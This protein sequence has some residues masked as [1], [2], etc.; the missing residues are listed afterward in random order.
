M[1]GTH[2]E[3]LTA[4]HAVHAG[5]LAQNPDAAQRGLRR[6]VCLRSGLERRGQQT[7]A[8]ELCRRLVERLVA[9]RTAAAQ[10]VVVHARQIVVNERIGMDHFERTR[11]RQGVFDVAA[12]QAAELEHDHRTQALA[13]RH[14]RL[15]NAVVA[16]MRLAREIALERR[17]DQR[18]IRAQLFGK[19][20]F[21]AS[22]AS[23]GRSVTSP[24]RFS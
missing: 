4:D 1:L 2:I 10:I 17:L 8:G 9:G 19:C 14:R 12:V 16:L 22:S 13:A 15:E 11:E 18:D 23:N 24:W 5:V 21:A 3:H 7:V 20:H 6:N